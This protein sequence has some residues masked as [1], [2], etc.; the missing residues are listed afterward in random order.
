MNTTEITQ[1]M[2][3]SGWYAEVQGEEQARRLLVNAQEKERQALLSSESVFY[4]RIQVMIARF[5]LGKNI[6]HDMRSLCKLY[7]EPGQQALIYLIH[8]QLYMSRKLSGARDSL[9]R[10]FHLATPYLG[11]DEYFLLMKR[12]EM[13]N[14]LVLTVKGSAAQELDEL[15]REASVIEKL[16][17]GKKGLKKPDHKDTIG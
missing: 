11:A 14:Y 3:L 9:A 16:S 5:W 2:P 8:G 10:G 17:G 15:L 12:H 6:E 7:R 13:L 4:P 1:T